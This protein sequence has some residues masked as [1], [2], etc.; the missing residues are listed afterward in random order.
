MIKRRLLKEKALTAAKTFPASD[1][2]LCPLFFT[3]ENIA[4]FL[5]C[6][7]F[8]RAG[9]ADC[10]KINT[11]KHLTN[12]YHGSIVICKE[13][14]RRR[15]NTPF[16]ARR[17]SFTLCTRQWSRFSTL[18]NGHIGMEEFH[19]RSFLFILSLRPGPHTSNPNKNEKEFE[20]H[21]YSSRKIRFNGFR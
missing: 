11:R 18:R 14:Q 7:N 15:R 20:S 8:C 17:F 13:R 2:R 1:E 10:T 19:C 6:V 12:L 16:F 3:V 9:R 21:E 5:F 4:D